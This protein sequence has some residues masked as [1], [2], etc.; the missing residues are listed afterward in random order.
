MD[1]HVLLFFKPSACIATGLS[2]F[3]AP[4]SFC[5]AFSLGENFMQENEVLVNFAILTQF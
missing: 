3:E 4:D 5:F 2:V 1:R